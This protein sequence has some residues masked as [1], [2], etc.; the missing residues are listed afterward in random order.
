MRKCED[1]QKYTSMNIARQTDIWDELRMQKISV[2][3][4]DCNYEKGKDADGKI[5]FWK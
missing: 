4:G 3:E 1:V 2:K 5:R